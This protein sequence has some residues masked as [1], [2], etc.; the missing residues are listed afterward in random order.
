MAWRWDGNGMEGIG[1]N[2]VGIILD[3]VRMG[4]VGGQFDLDGMGWDAMR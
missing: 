4:V 3:T 2:G 1:M